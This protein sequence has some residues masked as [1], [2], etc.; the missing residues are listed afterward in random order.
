MYID[1]FFKKEGFYESI[2]ATEQT[3]YEFGSIFRTHGYYPFE[4]LQVW[5][6]V[7]DLSEKTKTFAS[8]FRVKAISKENFGKTRSYPLTVPHIES[9][10]EFLVIRAKVRPVVLLLPEYPIEIKQPKA[11]GGKIYR[12]RCLIGQVFSLA[13]T[14]TNEA[15]FSTEFVNRVRELEYP[16]LM[17]LP[18]E[19]GLFSVPSLLR[20]D[21][22]QSVF[23]PHLTPSKFRLKKDIQSILRSQISYLLGTNDGNYY[24]E[25]RNL[26]KSE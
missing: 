4:N 25:H 6:E 5:E 24:T 22:C 26:L 7:P 12:R 13:D 16:Q 21:E 17:F 23:T 3:G 11:Y 8:Q 18:A 20:L 10:E 2:P 15:K 14:R 19:T 9:N 1:E